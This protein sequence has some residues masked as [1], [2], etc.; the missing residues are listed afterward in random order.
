VLGIGFQ[1]VLSGL[2]RIESE[3]A[4]SVSCCRE[5]AAVTDTRQFDDVTLQL[6]LFRA[7]L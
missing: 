6:V 3:V 1:I 5:F 7:V 2:K 4:V